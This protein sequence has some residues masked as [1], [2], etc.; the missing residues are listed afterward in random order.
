MSELTPWRFREEKAFPSLYRSR[1]FREFDDLVH[2]FFGDES[3]AP[4]TRRPFSP[5][6]D[7]RE[8]D[9]EFIV[10]GEI[11]GVD[12]KELDI[13]LRGQVLTIKG[14]KKDKPDV[15]YLHK[16]IGTRKFTKMF[17]LVDTME[18]LDTEYNDGILSI[19]L[20]NNLPKE[21]Q[22]KKISIK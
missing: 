9:E 3:L 10:T 14:E 18:V 4:S 13:N 7:I 21:K 20:H 2:R 22:A 5:A 12:P 16:G 1:F 11:P 6:I 15:K 8:T 19:K 17:G